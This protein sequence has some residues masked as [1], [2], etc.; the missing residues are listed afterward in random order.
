VNGIDGE[1]EFILE[2]DRLKNVMRKTR[3]I[4]N[5]RYENDAEHSWHACLMALALQ[6]RAN[7]P[8]D[9]SRVLQMLI[10]HDLGEIS[11]GDVIVY[12]RDSAHAAAELEAARE[13]LTPLDG[14]TRD[15]LHGF[16]EEFE[17][18]RTDD[19]K[20]ANAIDR[21][22]PLLQNICSGGET[23]RMRGITYEQ[24][25][26]V[27]EPKIREGSEQL[28]QFLRARIDGMREGLGIG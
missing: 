10:V 6:G 25:I 21:A 18:R 4:S 20:Y 19:A 23:W 22:G 12:L 13:L 8:V 14:A 16:L 28:W 15:R 24:I 5:D 17:A 11:G 1:I 26:R 9:I 2:A 27:N 3:N 7:F